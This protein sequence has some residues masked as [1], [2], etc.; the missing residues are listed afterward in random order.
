[1]DLLQ[2]RGCWRT[3]AA[4]ALV[5]V[6]APL[7][8]AAEPATAA[9]TSLYDRLGGLAP[10]SV[11]VDD[12]IDVLV[13][14]AQLN[15]NPAI[16]AARKRVPAAY[17]KFHVTTMVCQATGGPCQYTG[18]TMKDSHA[19]LHITAQEWDRMLVLFKQV[20][21]RHRVPERET[22]ELL[23]IVDSTRADIVTT[24]AHATGQK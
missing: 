22:G 24:G 2:R 12:F 13:P 10:I 8:R 21:A 7:T 9:A 4:T 16:D 14:D 11:V 6:I 18:R 23:A 17:L 5:L 3:L 20:L 1:M 15:A 19:H